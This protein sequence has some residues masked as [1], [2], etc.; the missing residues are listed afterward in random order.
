M[1]APFPL[2]CLPNR[3]AFGAPLRLGPRPQGTRRVTVGIL[4]LA[5]LPRGGPMN[6]G[7]PKRTHIVE[8]VESPVPQR[9]PSV[10][11][12]PAVPAEPTTVPAK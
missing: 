7:K 8:P 10:P 1:L 12:R 2:A 9:E 3:A 4:R 5:E 6:I 11:E